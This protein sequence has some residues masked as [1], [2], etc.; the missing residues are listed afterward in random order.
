MKRLTILAVAGLF[1]A[2]GSSVE[3]VSGPPANVPDR[4]V[5]GSYDSD[6]TEPARPGPCRSPMVDPRDGTRLRMV[7]AAEGM[8][9][10]AVPEGRYGLAAG[11][12]LRI[13]CAT[14]VPVGVVRR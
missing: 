3:L 1:A 7:A 12:Y 10:Y 14:G 6:A 9:D 5:V 8:G 4:F 11:E 13:E 2:C